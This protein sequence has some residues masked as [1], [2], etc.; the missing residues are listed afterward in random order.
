[1]YETHVWILFKTTSMTFEGGKP[2][3]LTD[4]TYYP[5]KGRFSYKLRLYTKSAI[6]QE[7]SNIGCSSPWGNRARH[8]SFADKPSSAPFAIS[9]NEIYSMTNIKYFIYSYSSATTGSQEGQYYISLGMSCPSSAVQHNTI[10]RTNAASPHKSF[11]L[12]KYKQ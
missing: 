3:E 4:Q 8:S 9:F 10:P 5:K 7:S 12:C 11:V 2:Q 6:T 1:M